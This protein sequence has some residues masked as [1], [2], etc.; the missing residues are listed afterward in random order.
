ME[1]ARIIELFLRRIEQAITETQLKYGKLC[2]NIAMNLLFNNEDA[3]EVVN[4]TYLGVWNAIPPEKPV[5]LMPFVCRVTKNI[6][7]DKLDYN[8]AKKRNVHTIMSFDELEDIVSGTS[9]VE[10]EYIIKEVAGYI[11]EFLKK[12]NRKR[13]IIFIRRYWYFDSIQQIAEEHRMSEN[14]VKS[15]LFRLRKKLKVYLEERGVEL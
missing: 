9:S 5:Y 2:K 11:S 8:N 10:E 15:E 7:M 13:R 3:D 14:T 4:D 1:D 12:Q 6:A